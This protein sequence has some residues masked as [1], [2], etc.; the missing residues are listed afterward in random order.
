VPATLLIDGKEIPVNARVIRDDALQFRALPRRRNTDAVMLHWTGGTNLGPTVFK[1]I[2]GRGL[3]VHLLIEPG[4]T[5]YQ[6]CD[7]DRLCSHGGK[8]DDTDHD[9]LQESANRC[10]IGIEIVNPANDQIIERGVRRSLVRETIHGHERVASSFTPEQTDTALSL[11]ATICGYYGLPVAVPMSGGDVLT[12]VMDENA[13]GKFRGVVGHY[14][15][16]STKRDPGLAIM[17]AVAALPLRGLNG[18]AE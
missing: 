16:K 11:V 13:F 1:V 8:V 14:M 4:G 12:T 9:G 18:A 3:S 17:R 15:T 2:R 10:T 5:V 7:L 6:Y